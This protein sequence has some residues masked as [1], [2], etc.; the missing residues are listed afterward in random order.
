MAGSRSMNWEMIEALRIKSCLVA[1]PEEIGAND[2]PQ[3]GKL[4][5]D[6]IDFDKGCYLGQRL[7]Q[8]FMP[9][10]MFGVRPALF[11]LPHR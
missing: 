5:L 4:E 11:N 8:E 2:L 10:V 9:W 7:W 6:Y 1:I 3:E